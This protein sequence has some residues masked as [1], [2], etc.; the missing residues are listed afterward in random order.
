MTTQPVDHTVLPMMKV[1]GN[2]SVLTSATG[3]VFTAFAAQ[4]CQQV[5]VVN[6]TGVDVEVQQDG[7]GAALP[8]INGTAYPFYGLTNAAQLAIRRVDNTNTQVT[9]KAR[10][11]G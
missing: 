11:E 4:T 6:N 8:V 10:W 1:G 2:T 9:V 7:A 3:A 5:T